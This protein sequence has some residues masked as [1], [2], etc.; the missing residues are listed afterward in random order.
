[1]FSLTKHIDTNF[2][3]PDCN[4]HLDTHGWY[5]PGMRML[6]DLECP[7]CNKEY[8]G[9]L[10]AGHGL[11]YPML[12]EKK[13]GRV[14]NKLGIEWFADWLEKS[15]ENS[16][17]SKITV[18]REDIHTVK[19]PVILN[20]LDGIY[21][22]ALLKL[23]NAQYYIDKHP[24]KDLVVIIPR[25]LRW[26]IPKG[27]ASIWTFDIPLKQGNQWNDWIA[28]FINNSLQDYND[29]YLSIGLPHPDP[30]NIDIERFTFVQPFRMETWLELLHGPKVTYVWRDDRLWNGVFTSN[31]KRK[32][33]KVFM[34]RAYRDER[35]NIELQRDNVIKLATILKERYPSLC[36]SVTGIGPSG[37]L[38]SWISDLRKH[39]ID[40]NTEKKWCDRYAESHVVVGV[41]GSNMLLPSALSGAVVELI[42]IKHWQNLLQDILIPH[43][44]IRISMTK[45]RFLN[46]RTSPKELADIIENLMQYMP[47]AVRNFSEKLT[48]H[49]NI[50][51]SPHV[52]S[53]INLQCFAP[54]NK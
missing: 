23:L 18:H 28:E 7:N 45:I 3:C 26:M 5:M 40:E 52:L 22:H 35:N 32:V 44:D 47:K 6:A 36:F 16:I 53:K 39:E 43:A 8:Y 9:D 15:Y 50:M 10:P 20:C 34:P 46:L 25:F 17:S 12:L 2:D 49:E 4:V 13:M 41:H 11:Y 54:I 33:K 29:C 48:N 51:R 37:D 14:H 31:F 1:M 27:V 42:P 30:S 19:C 24:D 38:P 21:G